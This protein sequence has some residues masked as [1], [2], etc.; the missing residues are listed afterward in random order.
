MQPCFAL[1]RARPCIT[2]GAVIASGQWV[3]PVVAPILR[4]IAAIHRLL[5]HQTV[6]GVLGARQAGGLRLG[7]T[8]T[9]KR[10]QDKW[11]IE[12]VKGFSAIDFRGFGEDEQTSTFLFLPAFVPALSDQQAS[13]K[14][15]F[16]FSCF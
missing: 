11:A 3:P 1:A 12:E 15:L 4:P 2:D 8:E 7:G 6:P 10:N 5:A 14:P 16:C 13:Q 9:R